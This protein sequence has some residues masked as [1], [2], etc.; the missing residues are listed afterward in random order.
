MMLQ[1]ELEKPKFWKRVISPYW[2][3]GIILIALLVSGF[4]IFKQSYPQP[5]IMLGQMWGLRAELHQAIN[6]K[7]YTRSRTLITQW[8]NVL[9]Q[10]RLS[11]FLHQ[12][13]LETEQDVTS[14]R[15]NSYLDDLTHV[16]NS[17]A[18]EKIHPVAVGLFELHRRFA[19]QFKEIPSGLIRGDDL[20]VKKPEFLLSDESKAPSLKLEMEK[21]KKG[22]WNIHLITENFRFSPDQ[23]SKKH[24]NGE[25]HA[26]LY[27][28]GK[29]MTR[30]YG[31]WHYLAKLPAGNHF[32]RITLNT[33]DEKEYKQNDQLIEVS[34][35]IK[36]E[37]DQEKIYFGT[38][39]PRPTDT[40]R[41]SQIRKGTN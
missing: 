32:I 23:V 33:N 14:Y 6:N 22:G 2:L 39:S 4:T 21:D 15:L 28:D 7:E 30:I 3:R 1:E 20:L 16:L 5:D 40:L 17:K 11:I 38:S 12:F 35:R 26:Q 25:G 31:N 27:V 10:F 34:R 41:K 36:I 29:F 24:A 18:S 9:S 19:S 37:N 8:K 13:N